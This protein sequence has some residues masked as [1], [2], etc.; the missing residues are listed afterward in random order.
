M[1]NNEHSKRHARKRGGGVGRGR[2][3]SLQLSGICS[4]FLF[5]GGTTLCRYCWFVQ[6]SLT[7]DWLISCEISTTVRRPGVNTEGEASVQFYQNIW[8]E[9][10]EKAVKLKPHV[11]SI[12][13]SV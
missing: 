3:A 4:G 1:S 12:L 11:L 8:S 5:V 7:T 2:V 9:T 10:Q 13:T 6:H